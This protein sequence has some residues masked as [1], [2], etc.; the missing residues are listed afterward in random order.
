MY[1]LFIEQFRVDALIAKIARCG[2][3][4]LGFEAELTVT[5]KDL[6][7][8]GFVVHNEKLVD[9]VRNWFKYGQSEERS[10]CPS[11]WRAS[12]EQLTEGLVN[13]VTQMVP[14]GRLVSVHARVFNHMGHTDLVW[15]KGQ[16]V[17]DFPRLATAE[18]IEETKEYNRLHGVES[19]C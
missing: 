12:C 11:I 9:L 2:G 13:V 17:P 6:D 5:T 3:Y 7:D 18:E 19:M 14:K 10:G 15:K 4:D 8:E 1:S 16:K